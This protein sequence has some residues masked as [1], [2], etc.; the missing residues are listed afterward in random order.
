MADCFSA[1]TSLNE[2][3]DFVHG[4]HVELLLKRVAYQSPEENSPIAAFG[5][6]PASYEGVLP[7]ADCPGIHYE[8]NLSADHGFYLNLRYIDRDYSKYTTGHWQLSD[9]GTKLML[10]S[11]DDAPVYFAIIGYDTLRLLDK[12]GRPIESTLNYELQRFAND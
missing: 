2:S 12:N 11:D 7:C 4:N 10:Q 1:G 6:F 8:V 5:K 9:N 3:T